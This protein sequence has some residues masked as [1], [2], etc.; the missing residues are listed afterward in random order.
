ML[1]AVGGPKW[2]NEFS[3]PKS[4]IETRKELKLLQI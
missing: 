4:I 2:D 1:G 3:K